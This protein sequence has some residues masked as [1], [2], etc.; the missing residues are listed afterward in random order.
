VPSA[1]GLISAT[2][3]Q[4][5]QPVVFAIDHNGALWESN[6]AFL[7]LPT[8]LGHQS[9]WRQL[10]SSSGTNDPNAFTQI[11]ADRNQS[12]QPVVF[13]VNRS[14]QVVEF[15]PLDGGQKVVAQADPTDHGIAGISATQNTSNQSVVFITTVAGGVF[16]YNPGFGGNGLLDVTTSMMRGAISAAGRIAATQDSAGNPIAY[17]EAHDINPTDGLNNEHSIWEFASG[18]VQQGVDPWF[19]ISPAQAVGFRTLSATQTQSGSPEVFALD[20]NGHIFEG[21]EP[22]SNPDGSTHFNFSQLSPAVFLAIDATR[23]TA[24]QPETLVAIDSNHNVQVA[25]AGAGMSVFLP[26]GSTAFAGSIAAT[27]GTSGQPVVFATDTFNHLWEFDSAVNQWSQ[28]TGVS[29]LRT[30]LFGIPGPTL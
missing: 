20:N 14:G 28:L 27:Q 15:N 12:G 30:R 8:L 26:N 2:T 17:I 4:S 22:G 3:N 11:S 29:S 9:S 19:A 24:T 18:L 7:S 5:G 1:S 10:T 21:F 25:P 16:E 23:G 13:G 6:P